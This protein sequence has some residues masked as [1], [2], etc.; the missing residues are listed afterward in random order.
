MLSDGFHVY[1]VGIRSLF[2]F[3]LLTYNFVI[4]L[5][6]DMGYTRHCVDGSFYFFI[7]Q[8][9]KKRILVVTKELAKFQQLSS[10]NFVDI[11]YH[12]FITTHQNNLHN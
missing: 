4:M 7:I 10:V 8:K 1:F 6:I 5:C 9:V 11:S 12:S 2:S 3:I